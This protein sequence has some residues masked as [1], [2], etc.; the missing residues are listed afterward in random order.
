VFVHVLCVALWV[1]AFVPLLAGLRAANTQGRAL[2]RFSRLIPYPLAALVL[3]GIA[4]ACVQLD[5]IDALWTTDYGRV[6]SGK[7]TAV[8]VLLG[9][10][11]ANRYRL[12]PRFEAEGAADARRLRLSIAAELVIAM[13]I[14]G[15]VGL[16]RFTPPPRA[17]A[18]AEPVSIHFHGGRA[19][20]QIEVEP[21]RGRG[22]Q[23]TVQVLDGEFRPLA[24]KEVT[25]VLSNPQAGIEPVRRT[26]TRKG[27]ALWR[28]DDLRIPIGGRWRL[29]VEI[30][31][32]DFDKVALDD[33]VELPPAP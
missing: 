11:A 4:L 3:S 13:T 18:A 28:I 30:L 5:R 22:A 21:V 24:A 9:L 32:D 29:R 12:M 10:A 2:A 19:M 17:I 1:G 25:L 8:L 16:W 15:L 14:L 20:A 7:L 31:I 27:R 6:L 23:V 26:G 33:D